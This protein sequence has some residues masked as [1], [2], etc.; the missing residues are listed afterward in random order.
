MNNLKQLFNQP[1]YHTEICADKPWLTHGV[2][3]S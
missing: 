1:D 2:C 3:I